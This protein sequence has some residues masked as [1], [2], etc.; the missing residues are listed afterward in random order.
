VASPTGW[1]VSWLAWVLSALRVSRPLAKRAASVIDAAFMGFQLDL[2]LDHSET[3]RE[4]AV[5]DLAD[6]VAALA[7]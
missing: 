4:Q 7:E 6:A 1:L 3:V 5:D 2:P